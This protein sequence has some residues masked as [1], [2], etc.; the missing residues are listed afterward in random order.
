M[1]NVMITQKTKEKLVSVLVA[2]AF[3]FNSICLFLNIL[4]PTISNFG[5]LLVI[6]IILGTAICV[7]PKMRVNA[8]L[9]SVNVVIM[10][11]MILSYV[12]YGSPAI[13]KALMIN[14]F[15][16]GI[17]ISI[18]MMQTFDSHTVLD[19]SF[20]IALII[21]VVDLIARVHSNYDNMVWTYAIF[22]SLAVVIVHFIYAKFENRLVR[23]FYLPGLIMLF[24]F[25][26]NANRGGLLSLLVLFFLVSIKSVNSE[27]HH[28]K[29]RRTGILL[30]IIVSTIGV[31]F[32]NQIITFLHNTLASLNYEIS[33]VNKMYRLILADNLTNNRTELYEFAWRG[34][35]ESPMWGNGIGGFSINH[36]GWA[37]N[38]ILQLLY[39]G[40]LLLT[41][42]ILI[43]LIK[44]SIFMLR[45]ENTTVEDYSLFVLLFATSIPRLFFSTELWNTQTFWML[46]AFCTITRKKY[47]ELKEGI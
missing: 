44:N 39:E 12:F 17:G 32:F 23:I 7:F 46:L 10:L 47:I 34:F 22:P 16:W 25:I 19:Y 29:S 38:F 43:P 9:L 3:L 5:E 21:I 11:A 35:L 45:N 30:L 13:I 37:H 24:K 42:L 40:G 14:Y 1:V 26:L 18:L 20:W 31:A 41:A 2:I 6:L 15:V 28:L 8:R 27:E 4:S 33:A 36:G